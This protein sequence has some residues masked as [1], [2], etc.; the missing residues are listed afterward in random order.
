MMECDV[1][2][3]WNG[4]NI[5]DF[6][7]LLK[8]NKTVLKAQYSS[9]VWLNTPIPTF[10]CILR[11]T[12]DDAEVRIRKSSFRAKETSSMEKHF[13]GKKRVT[14][15]SIEFSRLLLLYCRLDFFSLRF[16]WLC[17]LVSP[18]KWNNLSHCFSQC[19]F[20]LFRKR[21]RQLRIT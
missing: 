1:M 9:K 11:T 13:R 12:L 6:R 19:C 10:S 20:A 2:L 21:I 17:C 15:M 5:F 3:F 7:Q 16:V 4:I 14:I 18:V 8:L